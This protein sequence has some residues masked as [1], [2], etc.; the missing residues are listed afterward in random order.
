MVGRHV[1]YWGGIRHRELFPEIVLPS[2]SLSIL[3][4][5]MTLVKG[6]VGE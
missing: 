6:S 2:F 3:T 5:L 1:G 4:L